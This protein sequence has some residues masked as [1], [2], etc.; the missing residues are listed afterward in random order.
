M[1]WT[2][3]QVLLLQSQLSIRISTSSFV[4]MVSSLNKV[5]LGLV[6]YCI[7]LLSVVVDRSIQTNTG[8]GCSRPLLS[9][10]KSTCWLGF[11]Y[12]SKWGL[13]LIWIF[14]IGD[15]TFC[16]CLG[17]AKSNF[18]RVTKN[19]YLDYG[20][21]RNTTCHLT[22]AFIG[23]FESFLRRELKKMPYINVMA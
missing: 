14:R 2:N 5:S 8:K 21:I 20:I 15:A 16:L 22:W 3:L 4:D 10:N 6:W 9:L 18:L 17:S 19:R 23:V 7:V 1:L 13:M 12:C 11:L